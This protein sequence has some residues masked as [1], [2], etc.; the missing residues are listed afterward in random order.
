[1]KSSVTLFVSAVLIGVMAV[2]TTTDEEEY[3]LGE[4]VR[5][6][7]DLGAKPCE[8][9]RSLNASTA[10]K[11]L[12]WRYLM[13]ANRQCPFTLRKCDERKNDFFWS[14]GCNAKKDAIVFI[15]YNP[16]PTAQSIV[17]R[18]SDKKILTPT[19]RRVYSLNKGRTWL[20]MAFEPPHNHITDC[21]EAV[22]EPA[23]IEIP[24]YSYQTA[25][26]RLK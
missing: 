8:M 24:P 15:T 22:P 5:I 18:T 12:F 13:L 17:L 6:D 10:I 11:K 20:Q 7:L 9:K 25:T 1:M 14:V 21:Q 19:Y 2:A 4:P 26:V 23:T 16:G 3:D